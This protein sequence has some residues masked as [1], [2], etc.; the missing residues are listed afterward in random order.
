MCL[1]LYPYLIVIK[2]LQ[3]T[4]HHLV[5]IKQNNNNEKELIIKQQSKIKNHTQFWLPGIEFY[6]NT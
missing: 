5:V 2:C 1:I 6:F 4:Y 3:I